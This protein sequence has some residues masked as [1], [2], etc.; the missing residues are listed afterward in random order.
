MAYKNLFKLPFCYSYMKR[1]FIYLLTSLILFMSLV[2]ASTSCDDYDNVCILYENAVLHSWNSLEIYSIDSDSVELWV[3]Q[4]RTGDLREGDSYSSDKI[5]ITITEILY[6]QKADGISAIEFE[7]E[8][9]VSFPECEDLSSCILSGSDW[10]KVSRSDEINDFFTISIYSITSDSVR[11]YINGGLT[12]TND[13]KEG[14]NFFFSNSD[15]R[16]RVKDIMFNDNIN[17]SKVEFEYIFSNSSCSSGVDCLLSEGDIVQIYGKEASIT[18]IGKDEGELFV[19]EASSGRL[20]EGESFS[21]DLYNFII[22]EIL[23]NEKTDG[24]SKVAFGFN[25]SVPLSVYYSYCRGNDCI[26]AENRILTL[27][28]ENIKIDFIDADSVRFAN[29]EGV[30]FEDYKEGDV[31]NTSK[32]IIKIVAILYNSKANGVSKVEFGYEPIVF[33][34]E[35][36]E[37]NLENEDDGENVELEEALANETVDSSQTCNGCL[38][39]G[40]CYNI[41]YRE[42]GEYCNNMQEKA[43]QTEAGS[44]CENSFE[45]KSNL[46]IDGE[47]ISEGFFKRVMNWFKRLFG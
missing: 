2:N 13:L 20:R 29:G 31:F 15:D 21:V 36:L 10:I 26:L 1:N 22:E 18:F 41:G 12:L 32:N 4:N 19:G 42:A 45:C 37:K 14:G 47:C 46:C 23:Y 8:R 16:I 39:G 6:N 3:G 27:N 44:A 7:Y 40:K 9:L 35:N 38:V 30:V 43:V 25:K 34:E 11:L 5:K 24:V 33:M 28:E 17:N